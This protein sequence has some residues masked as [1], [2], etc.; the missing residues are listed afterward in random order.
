MK[1][2]VLKGYYGFGNFGDDLLMLVCSKWIKEVFPAST[3]VVSTASNSGE[4]IPR[5]TDGLVESVIST[6]PEPKADLI[7]HGG[8]GT[9]FDF[10]A[11]SLQYL[12][13]NKLIDLIGFTRFYHYLRKVR[14]KRGWPANQQTVRVALG[15]GVGGFEPDSTK[16]YYKAAE[17]GGFQLIVTRD[18][19]SYQYLV[20]RKLNAKIWASTDLCYLSR[21]WLTDTGSSD[22]KNK[23]IGL[24]V[25]SWNTAPSY[26]KVIRQAADILVSEGFNISVFFFE[27]ELDSAVGQVFTGFEQYYWDPKVMGISTYLKIL[28]SQ[29]IIVTAR[30][31][32]A[33]VAS[34]LGIPSVCIGVEPK[35]HVFHSMLPDSSVYVACP[36]ILSTLLDGIERA[37]KIPRSLIIRDFR[38]NNVQA[39]SSMV[40]VKEWLL[41]VVQAKHKPVN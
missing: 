7:I 3:L 17:L 19:L 35:L 13:L 31:H 39:E 4:Y 23:R 41:Y 32:G 5:L 27:K 21:Y 10:G 25:R 26:L 40:S 1:K 6:N 2:I 33:L 18:N 14:I 38:K 22:S 34:A 29:D 8:G 9:Y 12:A 30:A 24:V 20:K 11:G 15:I 37:F 16:Y 28:S 36:L